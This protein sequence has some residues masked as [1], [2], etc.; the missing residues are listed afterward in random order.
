MLRWLGV[1]VAYVHLGKQRA[2]YA[3]A[4]QSTIQLAADSAISDELRG[5]N[6]S[7]V[8]TLPIGDAFVAYGKVGAF[9]SRLSYSDTT[10]VSSIL[11]PGPPHT[12]ENA[13]TS[14]QTRVSF[15]LGGE[16]RIADQIS[17]R[18]GWDRFP[19][20]GDQ[21]IVG[22]FNNVDFLSGGILFRF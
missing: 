9:R 1:E 18:G 20:V 6:A 8:G 19:N 3:T 5:L 16:Y 17:L 7:V 10:T 15:G 11:P 12:V 21:S 4:L 2:A 22:H 14:R 13:G